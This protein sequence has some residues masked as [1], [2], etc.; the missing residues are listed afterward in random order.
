[1]KAE[2]LINAIEELVRLADK[3]VYYRD[4]NLQL[5]FS[6]D[7]SS[8]VIGTREDGIVYLSVYFGFEM[9]FKFYLEKNGSVLLDQGS[10][11]NLIEYSGPGQ[12]LGVIDNAGEALL[13]LG[14]AAIEAGD[15]E[16]KTMEQVSEEF[17][18]IRERDIK[19]EGEKH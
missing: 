10:T 7:D 9:G 17:R 6:L 18:K 16:F 2:K 13:T 19:D 15:Y 12:V 11:A 3:E 1:M 4:D 14:R 5:R 8:Y